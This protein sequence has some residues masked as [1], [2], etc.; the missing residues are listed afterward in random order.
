VRAEETEPV[1]NLD[2]HR[3]PKQEGPPCEVAFVWGPFIDPFMHG[4]RDVLGVVMEP[5]AYEAAVTAC[6]GGHACHRCG[7]RSPLVYCGPA[8]SFEQ[9]SR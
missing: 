3:A 2:E 9:I 1:V 5:I 7:G 6:G 8:S 4:A